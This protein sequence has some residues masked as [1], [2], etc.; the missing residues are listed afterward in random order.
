MIL[1]YD[2]W[3]DTNGKWHCGDCRALSKMS[4]AWWK[5]ARLLN[6]ELTDYIKMMKETYNANIKATKSFNVILF[7]WDKQADMRKF[8]NFINRKAR[9]TG[10]HSY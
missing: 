7:S 1:K 2:E 10:Y 5:P 6:M 8:K 9:E 4:N 3:Q